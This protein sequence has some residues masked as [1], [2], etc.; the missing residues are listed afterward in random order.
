MPNELVMCGIA[1]QHHAV[2]IRDRKDGSDQERRIGLLELA[3]V[4]AQ[5]VEV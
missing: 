2:G 1:S 4:L 3:E 5:P